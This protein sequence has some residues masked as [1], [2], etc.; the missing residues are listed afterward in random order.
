MLYGI[1][2]F[3][4]AFNLINLK[5]DIF[6]L[7]I[8]F[9]ENILS[10]DILFLWF[11][12]MLDSYSAYWDLIMSTD[13]FGSFFS[14]TNWRIPLKLSPSFYFVICQFELEFGN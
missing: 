7:I 1:D 14:I 9:L 6:G 8:F 10:N 2:I 3:E 13:E 4:P 5:G 11:I 12:D